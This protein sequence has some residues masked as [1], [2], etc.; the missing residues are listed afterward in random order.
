MA[1]S[2]SAPSSASSACWPKPMPWTSSERHHHHVMVVDAEGELVGILSALDVVA[3]V[4]RGA[5]FD[6]DDEDEREPRAGRSAL[7]GN[8]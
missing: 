1:S 6:L 8:P 4:A 2:P 5:R 7:E 3:A